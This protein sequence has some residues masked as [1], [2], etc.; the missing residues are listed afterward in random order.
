MFRRCSVCSHCRFLTACSPA[1]EPVLLPVALPD[2]SGMHS[3]V[4]AQLRSAEDALAAGGASE[5]AEAHGALGML[6]MA[7]DYL[8]AAEPSLRNARR[9]A[10]DE[11]R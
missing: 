10:P 9:V 4:Q 1:A 11:F 8:E 3:A 6:L 2:L 5:R 7:G